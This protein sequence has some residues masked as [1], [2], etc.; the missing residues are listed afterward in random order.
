MALVAAG[1]WEGLYRIIQGLGSWPARTPFNL[2]TRNW[3]SQSVLDTPPPPGLGWVL[4][5]LSFKRLLA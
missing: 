2:G 5:S 1:I 3:R 4:I